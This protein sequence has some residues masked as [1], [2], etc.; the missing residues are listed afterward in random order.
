MPL[1]PPEDHRG[2]DLHSAAHGRPPRSRWTSSEGAAAR[3]EPPLE[4]VYPKGAAAH[5]RAGEKHEEEGVAEELSRTDHSP[6]SPSLLHCSRRKE[7]G[8]SEQ[9]SETEPGKKRGGEKVF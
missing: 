1:Q 8:E 7:V 5:A 3:G 6:H 4:Q 9:G 2:A